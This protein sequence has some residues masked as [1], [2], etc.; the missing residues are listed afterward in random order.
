MK[1][2]VLILLA[3]LSFNFCYTQ[4]DELESLNKKLSNEKTDTGKVSVLNEITSK[5]IA[6]SEYKTA[7]EN[8]EKSEKLAKSI[9]FTRGLGTALNN[10]GITHEKLG[11]FDKAIEYNQKALQ[12][13]EQIS[14]KPGMATTLNSLGIVFWRKGLIDKSLDYHL[15]TLKTREELNDKPGIASSYNNLGV[16]HNT[17]NN[18]DKALEYYLLAA[19]IREE[20]G[21]KV[22]MG[23]IFNNIGIVYEK[24]GDRKKSLEYY[25]KAYD[26]KKEIGDKVGI[27][28]SLFN[29]GNIYET[30][31]DYKKAMEHHLA[32]LEIREQLQDKLGI[33]TSY[34]AIGRIHFKNGDYGLSKTWHQK[35]LLLAKE[36]DSK[37]E[38]MMSY[39]NLIQVDSVT[40][41]YKDAYEHIKRFWELYLA[42][43]NLQVEKK[44]M[45]A[46]V[47]YEF[48]KKE[49]LAKAEQEKKE[50]LHKSE[51]SKQKLQRNAFVLGFLFMLILA[52]LSYLNYRNKKKANIIITQQKEEV[53]KQKHIIEEKQREVLDSINYAKR[54]QQA[55]LPSFAKWNSYLK[56]S[57][58]LYMPKDIVA[59]DFY[60]MDT[61]TKNNGEEYVFVAVADCTGHGVPGAMVSVVCSNALS[62]AVLE[63]KIENTSDIL[64]RVRDIV[65]EK[66]STTEENIRD[67]M[68]IC[69]IR[70]HIKTGNL[71]YSGANRPLW[72]FKDGEF[73]ELKPDKQPIGKFE[74]SKKF[75]TQELQLEK[76]TML[77]LVTDGYADQFGGYKSRAGGKKMG[78]KT[79][80]EQLKRIHAKPLDEQATILRE[81]YYAWKEDFEQ[82][83][84]VTI[85][86]IR[87]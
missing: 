80:K 81:N 83:D 27:S 9:S 18:F 21:E 46:E 69:L 48:E 7:L 13:F 17:R 57:F 39:F 22:Y 59:G 72:Y 74:N 73:Y 41:N 45:E 55:I 87:L 23:S 14:Y 51:L 85:V 75:T 1:N 30:D 79:L 12:L 65:T 50:L 38:T 42:S 5:L 20:L 53:E 44:M 15:K 67:G 70:L 64:D 66:L 32:A 71:Q 35:A 36:I 60:W 77:Y 76:D 49:A 86:G 2:I 31:K 54:I 28:N 68:D 10:Q 3:F 56:N 37:Q 63:E 78:V 6:I 29:I 4:N 8:A 34:N 40:K 61:I 84:D 25:Q 26:I 11:D 52:S 82:V 58:I 24:K 16:I 43:N 33:A 47:N 62:K 19:K